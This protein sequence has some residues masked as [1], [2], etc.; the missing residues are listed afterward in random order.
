MKKSDC[1]DKELKIVYLLSCVN[2][3]PPPP[4]KPVNSVRKRTDRGPQSE[5]FWAFILYIGQ[6]V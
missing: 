4:K 3:T 1:F 5:Q 2:D 6:F